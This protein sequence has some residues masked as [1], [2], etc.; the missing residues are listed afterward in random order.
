MCSSASNSTG[1]TAA[2]TVTNLN[3]TS[4]HLL[5]ATTTDSHNDNPATVNGESVGEEETSNICTNGQTNDHMTSLSLSKVGEEGSPVTAEA[6]EPSATKF[7]E[8]FNKKVVIG[9]KEANTLSSASFTSNEENNKEQENS[10][11]SENIVPTSSKRLFKGRTKPAGVLKHRRSLRLVNQKN[12]TVLGDNAATRSKT[13]KRFSAFLAH[14]LS[15]FA[16]SSSPST[17]TSTSTNISKKRPRV[18]SSKSL[19]SC[20]S[21]QTSSSSICHH[22]AVFKEPQ[23]PSSSS[24]CALIVPASVTDISEAAAVSCSNESAGKLVVASKKS[25][26]ATDSTAKK[27]FFK[28]KLFKS[29]KPSKRLKSTKTNKS[30]DKAV[31]DDTGSSL[32]NLPLAAVGSQELLSTATINSLTDTQPHYLLP[33]E[34]YECPNSST[35]TSSSSLTSPSSTSSILE[36]AYAESNNIL[37]EMNMSDTNNCFESLNGAKKPEFATLSNPFDHTV[38][39]FQSTSASSFADMDSENSA[40]HLCSASN[41][42]YNA[43]ASSSSANCSS[44]PSASQLQS[45][46]S[47]SPSLMHQHHLQHHHLQHLNP[48]HQHHQMHTDLLFGHQQQLNP[49]ASDIEMIPMGHHSLHQVSQS[50]QEF[51]FD[52][53]SGIC[54]SVNAL[55]AAAAHTASAVN[56]ASAS[57]NLIKQDLLKLSYDKF[58][59]YRLNEKL[60]PQTVLIR[61]AI[62]L[63]QY[64]LQFQQEQEQQQHQQIFLQ[65]QQ[66]QHLQQQQQ[67]QQ[68][69]FMMNESGAVVMTNAGQLDNNNSINNNSASANRYSSSSS[70]SASS[71]SSSSQQQL[72]TNHGGF[73]L[74]KPVGSNVNNIISMIPYENLE[75]F[76]NR[77]EFSNNNPM[78]L[79]QQNTIA[80]N[81]SND[82]NT[83]NG[84]ACN[85]SHLNANGSHVSNLTD[86]SAANS[87]TCFYVNMEG[88]Q[89]HD[90]I[91]LGN[92]ANIATDLRHAFYNGTSVGSASNSDITDTTSSSGCVTSHQTN[93]S[94]NNSEGFEDDEEEEEEEEDEEEEDEEEDEDEEGG[95]DDEEGGEDEDEEDEEEEEGEGADQ[96]QNGCGEDEE[97]EEDEEED[98]GGD[99]QNH[100]TQKVAQIESNEQSHHGEEHDGLALT[101]HVQEYVH[102]DSNQ[103]V[104]LS[105]SSTVSTSSS[106]SVSSSSSSSSDTTLDENFYVD[107]DNFEHDDDFEEN[108][109]LVSRTTSYSTI[110]YNQ[111]EYNS[112]ASINEQSN[113]YGTFYRSSDD[114]SP[115]LNTQYS[116]PTATA[117][118]A[119]LL[120][121]TTTNYNN[122]ATVSSSLDATTTGQYITDNTNSDA[123]CKSYF[124]AS[125][126][127]QFTNT[128]NYNP[129][130]LKNENDESKT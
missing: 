91:G 43:A 122:L 28:R 117:T 49:F 97:E 56:V 119:T 93:T 96:D 129:T 37:R 87:A 29:F 24:T 26:F 94:S 85:G 83:S 110:T 34:D 75:E 4:D 89:R 23:S 3:S 67:Q 59:Q 70:P 88:A 77:S 71:S 51:I 81:V 82:A 124:L 60:L 21:D 22:Q 92:S 115:S 80:S 20:L 107:I 54:A 116:N 76:F 53:R 55:A 2:S 48:H 68:M 61:N 41:F 106:P 99:N 114:P 1:L 103:N 9:Q 128:T 120:S 6:E 32:C 65:Q 33:N 69:E 52:N 15:K 44:Q 19:F 86:Q 127:S 98:D 18:A 126:S 125:S 73:G 35:T 121:D 64:D 13:R 123:S 79:T 78:M 36:V 111:R 45:S 90:Q 42:G 38:Q 17:S 46:S 39:A 108:G 118:V 58:K 40:N 31:D 12:G 7:V 5:G 102:I 63:L 112:L 101:K 16:S 27:G 105:S 8:S 104:A 10:A 62:K 74:N 66:Q 113:F 130:N 50:Q 30:Q 57:N 25:V 109:L 47:S 84:A 14:K 95:E 100:D 72:I 11:A